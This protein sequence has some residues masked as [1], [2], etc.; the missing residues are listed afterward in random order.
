MDMYEVSANHHWQQKHFTETQQEQRHTPWRGQRRIPHHKRHGHQ[1]AGPTTGQTPSSGL[2]MHM[3]Q[4][5]TPPST[6]N[7]TPSFHQEASTSAS[8]NRLEEGIEPNPGPS[9]TRQTLPHSFHWTRKQRKVHFNCCK[10]GSTRRTLSLCKKSTSLLIKQHK[11]C[12][13]FTRQT[14]G[15]G[16]LEATTQLMPKVD[17]MYMKDS[18]PWCTHATGAQESSINV[19]KIHSLG[20]LTMIVASF[21]KGHTTNIETCIDS[22]QKID[23]SRGQP[24]LC[25]G[26]FNTH[27][28]NF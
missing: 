4:A 16:S 3:E 28:C 15:V 18:W 7:T 12:S 26:D 5:W 14:T 20:P 10:T 24:I 25:K 19:K 27:V 23:P 8:R 6:R 22:I 17:H 9:N 13:W 11:K 1:Y 2:A 21:Y